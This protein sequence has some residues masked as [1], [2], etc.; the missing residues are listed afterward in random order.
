[1]DNAV[2][3]ARS[4]LSKLTS[5][6]GQRPTAS[7]LAAYFGISTDRLYQR[8]SPGGAGAG[9][10]AKKRVRVRHSLTDDGGHARYRLR[11]LLARVAPY[12]VST[13]F[14]RG[15]ATAPNDDDAP[16]RARPARRRTPANM[17]RRLRQARIALGKMDAERKASKRM[18]RDDRTDSYDA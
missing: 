1:M 3:S 14:T 11:M 4:A 5:P 10:V 12:T 8:T 2:A 16:T 7:A 9:R 15:W 17:R 6:A 18:A 13:A